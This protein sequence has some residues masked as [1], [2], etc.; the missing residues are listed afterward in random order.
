[1]KH[2]S[3]NTPLHWH[4]KDGKFIRPFRFNDYAKTI[5]F[6]NKVAA[7]ADEMDHHP[8]MLVGYNT[9]ECTIWSHSAGGVTPQCVEF[10]ERVNAIA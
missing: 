7:I 1:M 4:L 2:D 10:C 6:V 3:I 5:E 9:V 8:N